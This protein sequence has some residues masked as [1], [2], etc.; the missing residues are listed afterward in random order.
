MDLEINKRIK[1]YRNLAN[2]TQDETAK[3]LG[4]KCSTYSQ[5]E[6]KGGISV[7]I[8]KKLAEIFGIDSD[9]IIYGEKKIDFTPIQPPVL[10]VEEPKE[11]IEKLESEATLSAV[12]NNI[13][14][15]IRNL[16]YKD[17]QEVYQFIEKKYK[18]EL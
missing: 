15:I 12:E 2:K 17:R 8:A 18:K 3:A 1:S 6:R 13:I 10:K 4:I 11:I 7:D 16:S 5:M 14:K 9:L